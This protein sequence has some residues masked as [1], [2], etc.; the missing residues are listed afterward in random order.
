[1]GAGGSGRAAACSNEERAQSGAFTSARDGDARAK[2]TRRRR[3]A[4]RQAVSGGVFGVAGRAGR[5]GRDAGGCAGR[6]NLAAAHRDPHGGGQARMALRARASGWQLRPRRALPHRRGTADGA[7]GGAGRR[8]REGVLRR[9]VPVEAKEAGQHVGCVCDMA[10]DA[11]SGLLLLVSRT[12][13]GAEN[14]G[15]IQTADGETA[16][17]V[18]AGMDV[19]A[20]AAD[21]STRTARPISAERAE[22][23][24]RALPPSSGWIWKKTNKKTARGR[25]AGA[26]RCPAPNRRKI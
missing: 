17:T 2:P 23:T 7:G 15:A 4:G 13:D 10:Y 22:A 21:P 5:R 19:G 6:R 9:I 18:G 26:K 1:M 25:R 3:E 12:E 16:W 8:R 24:G 20:G 14:V 11:E